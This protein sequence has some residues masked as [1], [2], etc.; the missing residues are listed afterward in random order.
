MLQIILAVIGL[1][2]V[3]ALGLVTI[4][5]F[6]IQSRMQDQRENIRRLD[7]AAESI[8]G[9]LGRLPGVDAMLAP[10]PGT[11]GDVAYSVIPSGLGGVNATVSG[12]PFLYCPVAP[13]LSAAELDG[14]LGPVASRPAA[15][16]VSMLDGNYN[17]QT[18]QNFVVTDDLAYDSALDAFNPVAFIVAAGTLGDAPVDCSSIQVVNGRAVVN[19]GI[20]RVVTAPT[21]PATAASGASVAAEFWV[22]EGGTGIGTQNSPSSVNAA[23]EHF[24]RYRPTSMT[25][26]L[27]GNNPVAANTLSRF[28]AASA[29]SGANFR[30]VG[31]SDGTLGGIFNLSGAINWDIPSNTVLENVT[32]RGASIEVSPGDSLF[33]VGRVDLLTFS[34]SPIS[35]YV[36]Q[37]GR[38]AVSNST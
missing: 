26:H 20:V 32:V 21:D 34:G 25:I 1:T 14:I 13:A 31:H 30:L 37:G 17:I 19:G 22:Q 8:Q 24:V 18:S 27:V 38:L 16:Q 29:D 12:I 9:S 3:G 15:V 6:A 33:T 7:I 5:Q 36:R 11:S 4:Q 10:I 28:L 35:V 2:I 23:L